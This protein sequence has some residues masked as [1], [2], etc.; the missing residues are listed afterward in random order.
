[1][2]VK[3][4]YQNYLRLDVCKNCRVEQ[5]STF[6][7]G[8]CQACYAR[9]RRAGTLDEVADAPFRNQPPHAH[10]IGHRTLRKSGYINIKTEDGG[11]LEHR[12][13][14]EKKLGRPLRSDENVHHLN[15][16][17]DDNRPENLEL[18]HGRGTQ[19]AGARPDDL[20]DY[21]VSCHFDAVWGAVEAQAWA[22]NA[23][24]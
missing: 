12:V 23:V 11:R 22:L 6:T 8:L 24:A 18:W 9:H 5:L 13:V 2:P 7:R 4:R 20:I 3:S 16:I 17:K 10:P 14:M 15:G 21:I 1:L 19:P